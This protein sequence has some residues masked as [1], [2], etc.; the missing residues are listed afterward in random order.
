[1]KRINPD[2]IKALLS[3]AN[4]GPFYELLSMKLCEVD[5]CHSKVEVDL[6]NKH[7]NP[8]GRIHGGVYS[9]AIDTAAYWAAYCELDENVGFTTIDLNVDILSTIKEG[10]IIVEGK[11]LK[12]GRSICLSEATAK[13]M[14]GKLLAHGTSKMLVVQG[15][16]SISHAVDA[17][18]Y[19]ALPPKFL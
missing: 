17:M 19:H 5:I 8:F 10:K 11:S 13:D 3:L 16:Q 2:H 7:Q 18:G 4:L 6:G 1:M 15:L 14:G 9:A 12:I